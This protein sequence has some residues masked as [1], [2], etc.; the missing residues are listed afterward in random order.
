V[1][2]SICHRYS[3]AMKRVIL[4]LVCAAVAASYPTDIPITEPP[5]IVLTAPD[6]VENSIDNIATLDDCE[7]EKVMSPVSTKRN[8]DEDEPPVRRRCSSRV[9]VR[10]GRG[11][12]ADP[13]S[14]LE[15]SGE[16]D[17]G[18]LRLGRGRTSDDNFIRFGRGGRNDNFIRLG[19]DRSDNFIRFGRGRTDNFI[20]FGRGKSDNFIRF[21]RGR[22]DNFIRLGRDMENSYGSDENFNL[23]DTYTNPEDEI[24][25]SS[26]LRIGRGGKLDSN[27]IRFGRARP[28]G[29]NF[30]RLGRS[31]DELTQP[32]ES[33]LTNRNFVRLGRQIYEDNPVRLSR[34]SGNNDDLRR[35]KLADQNFI[36]LGRSGQPALQYNDNR[37]RKRLGR[38]NGPSNSHSFVR[39]GKRAEQRRLVR[40]G[41]N[42]QQTEDAPTS[43]HGD[44]APSDNGNKTTKVEYQQNRKRRSVTFSNE[45]ETPEDSSDYPIIISNG[46]YDDNKMSSSFDDSQ[47]PFRYYS[48]I[49]SGIPNYIL[50]PELSVLAPLRI[51]AEIK[52]GQVNG[53]NRNYIRLG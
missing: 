15:S 31:N 36:R 23:E 20:R 2:F 10:L 1:L 47:I 30:I 27:F 11:S 53:H 33:G 29:S 43:S 17:T 41:R 7:T 8:E 28:S 51:G 42:V 52:R 39:L 9:F 25:S 48:P 45:D 3:A 12:S 37:E 19:R 40:F 49:V 21:G 5:N 24:S 18:L 22:Q 32:E 34:S 26:N 38:Y 46:A 4:V 6:D 35:G 44:S 14:E 16:K 50:G 13:A